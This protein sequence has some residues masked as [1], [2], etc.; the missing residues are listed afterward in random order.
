MRRNP[1]QAQRALTRR[2][3]LH[4]IIHRLNLSAFHQT[5]TPH[6]GT[7]PRQ[8]LRLEEQGVAGS[9][10]QAEGD[11]GEQLV[12]GALMWLSEAELARQRGT[13]T[14]TGHMLGRS[15]S[16]HS[17]PALHRWGTSLQPSAW[18]SASC[19]RS[20]GGQGWQE[21]TEQNACTHT[22]TETEHITD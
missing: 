1:S 18:A 14:C 5:S 2:F 12:A 9:L 6:R 22:K 11:G 3:T 7:R 20:T 8:S 19:R 16:H 17:G 10:R 13:V 21:N 15:F 4:Q